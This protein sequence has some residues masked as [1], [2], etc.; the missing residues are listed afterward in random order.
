MKKLEIIPG[1]SVVGC[2]MM[3]NER[4]KFSQDGNRKEDGAPQRLVWLP[5]K[6]VSGTQTGPMVRREFYFSGR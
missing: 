3:L 6:M 4:V 2:V 5:S 1:I